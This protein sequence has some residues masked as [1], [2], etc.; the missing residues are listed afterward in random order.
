V[1]TYQL[2]GI[3]R[4]VIVGWINRKS[5]NRKTGNRR[6]RSCRADSNR[7]TRSSASRPTTKDSP[8]T[9]PPHPATAPNPTSHVQSLGQ[10]HVP[11]LPSKP[12]PEISIKSHG[13]SKPF[14]NLP[15][16]PTSETSVKNL[17]PKPAI[18]AA[19]KIC[20]GLKLRAPGT[21]KCKF[22]RLTA[23]AARAARR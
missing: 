20:R 14:A 7:S 16:K 6:F 17:V 10:N 12:R 8:T 2:A 1:S 18:K 22:P 19:S 5:S 13:L 11:N 3:I 15:S 23:K 21:A 4:Q 9:P